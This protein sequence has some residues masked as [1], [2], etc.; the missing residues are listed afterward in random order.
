MAE[1]WATSGGNVR[2]NIFDDK[3]NELINKAINEATV[4]KD[5]TRIAHYESNLFKSVLELC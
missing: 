5:R 3:I 1:Q 4:E 2:E